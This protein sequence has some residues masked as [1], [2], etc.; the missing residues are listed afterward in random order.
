M[1]KTKDNKK[2]GKSVRV[3]GHSYERQ[4][5][6][7]FRKLGW[8]KA[9]TSRQES[10]RKD[11][12]GVD[13]CNTD[14]LQIQCKSLNIFKSPVNVLKAMPE[15]GFYNVVFTKVVHKGEFVTMNKNDFYTM[16]EVLKAEKIF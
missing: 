6:E 10:R 15:N 3:R 9:L 2:R 1:I 5:A 13:L 4:I 7:E 8:K 11:N 14:P 12:E 16:L